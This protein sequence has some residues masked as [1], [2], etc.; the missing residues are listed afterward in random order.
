MSQHLMTLGISKREPSKREDIA[1]DMMEENFP[2]MKKEQNL[3]V[4]RKH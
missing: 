4:E 1:N 2:E 3:Q